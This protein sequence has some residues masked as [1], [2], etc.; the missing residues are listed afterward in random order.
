MNL[1]EFSSQ[2]NSINTIILL[3]GKRNVLEA[4]QVK[5]IQLGTLLVTHLP[6]V[7]LEVATQMVLTFIFYKESLKWHLSVCKS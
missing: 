3:E 7:T 4:D 6:L 1:K 2:F 5:L